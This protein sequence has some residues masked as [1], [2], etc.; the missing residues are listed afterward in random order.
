MASTPKATLATLRSKIAEIERVIAEIKK[1]LSVLAA[2]EEITDQSG[3]YTPEPEVLREEWKRLYESYVSEGPQVVERFANAR[4]ERFLV[5]FC[6]ANN[7]ALG[8]G[9]PT[10]QRVAIRIVQ[11]MSE[12]IALARRG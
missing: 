2:E 4:S 9:Q 11:A 3:L 1:E 7:V 10:K 6:Q 12:R 8:D 5:S